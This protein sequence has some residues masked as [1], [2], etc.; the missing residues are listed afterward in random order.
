M[1]VTVIN[2]SHEHDLP[3]RSELLLHSLSWEGNSHCKN[4]IWVKS[5]VVRE[6]PEIFQLRMYKQGQFHPP[7]D[8]GTHFYSGFN[9]WHQCIWKYTRIEASTFLHLFFFF[10]S[11]DWKYCFWNEIPKQCRVAWFWLKKFFSLLPEN[12]HLFS[13]WDSSVSFFPKSDVM[14]QALKRMHVNMA[15]HICQ[16]LSPVFF[17]F[18]KYYWL[19]C[20]C[21]Y[22]LKEVLRNEEWEIQ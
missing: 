12:S 11:F 3:Q 19:P 2:I 22:F 10:Q 8:C 5:R 9:A 1:F 13:A 6:Q 16:D 4:S 21:I 7:G 14:R 18:T 15:L 17:S 20:S